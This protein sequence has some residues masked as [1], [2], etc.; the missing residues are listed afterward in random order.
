MTFLRES[1][2][3]LKVQVELPSVA[4]SRAY[5]SPRVDNTSFQALLSQVLCF[6]QYSVNYT[7]FLP[8]LLLSS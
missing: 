7:H 8:I 6:A 4:N 1:T 5:Y 2:C 3:F